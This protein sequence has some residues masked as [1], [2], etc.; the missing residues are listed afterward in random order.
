[1]RTVS[2][3]VK[4]RCEYWAYNSGTD[5]HPDHTLQFPARMLSIRI[6]FLYFQMFIFNTLSISVRNWAYTSGTDVCTKHTH[7]E[8][9]HALSIQVMNWCVHWAYAKWHSL[10]LIAISGPK[11]VSISGPTPSNGGPRYGFPPSKSICPAPYKKT[12]TLIVKNLL[13]FY[14]LFICTA[15]LLSFLQ[16][17]VPIKLWH[18]LSKRLKFGFENIYKKFSNPCNFNC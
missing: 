9:M 2:I 1:M 10:G 16:P 11:K 17:F 14:V 4:N 13:C 18:L 7:Q 8:L 12:G 15:V 5:A 3:R 6:S